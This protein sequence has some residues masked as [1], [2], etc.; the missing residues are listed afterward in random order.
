M[1]GTKKAAL[2][3]PLHPAPAAKKPAK[4][5]RPVPKSAARHPNPGNNRSK[6]AA[7]ASARHQTAAVLLFAAALL[8]FFIVL[9]PGGNVW[10]ALHNFVLGLFGICSYILPVLLIYIAVICAMDKPIGSINSKLWQCILLLMMIGGAIQVFTLNIPA[11][12][13][14]GYFSFLGK[15]YVN[16]KNLIAAVLWA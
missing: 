9:I 10:K 8:L 3:R 6:A 11:E 1:H 2:P 13:G 15:G 16:G 4:A 12:P 14:N 7:I 5:A